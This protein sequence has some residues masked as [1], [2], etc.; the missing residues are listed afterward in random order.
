MSPIATAI[1]ALPRTVLRLGVD[2]FTLE[3]LGGGT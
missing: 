1:A 3:R 2:D